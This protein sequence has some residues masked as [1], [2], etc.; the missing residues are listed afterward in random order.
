MLAQEAL[1]ESQLRLM[2]AA[3]EWQEQEQEQEQE[4]TVSAETCSGLLCECHR[5]T[6]SGTHQPFFCFS[7]AASRV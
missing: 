1:D 3:S 6:A 2:L 4:Q 7:N 5:R